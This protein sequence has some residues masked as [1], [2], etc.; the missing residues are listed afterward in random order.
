MGTVEHMNGDRPA[1]PAADFEAAFFHTILDQ[2]TEAVVVV[3]SHDL[4]APDSH[5]VYVNAAF[6]RLTGYPAAELR[7]CRTGGGD[8]DEG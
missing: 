2:M 5:M 3:R 4:T 1:A 7:C 8:R 6:E